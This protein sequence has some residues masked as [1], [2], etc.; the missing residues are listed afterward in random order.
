MPFEL[1]KVDNSKFVTLK[2]MDS[3][4]YY[5]ELGYFDEQG[6]CVPEPTEPEQIETG[7]VKRLR[8]GNG[9][10]IFFRNDNTVL[11]KYEG[12]WVK[13]QKTGEGYTLYPDQGYYSGKYFCFEKN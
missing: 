7:K 12:Q 3:S 1:S 9:A 6:N 2:F 11:C 10:Q 4:V 5:G 13:D 8:H